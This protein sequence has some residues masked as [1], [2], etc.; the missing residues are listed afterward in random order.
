VGKAIKIVAA[1][2][3]TFVLG[4]IVLGVMLMSPCQTKTDRARNNDIPNIR[5]ALVLYFVRN[6]RPARS[7]DD[8]VRAQLLDR[9]P[10]DPWANRYRYILDGYRPV[11]VSNGEDGLP[12]SA[13]DISSNDLGSP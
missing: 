2:T 7:F 8:L 1:I 6:A 4:V 11:V 9:V 13:D 5:M 10:Y 12:G 3:L